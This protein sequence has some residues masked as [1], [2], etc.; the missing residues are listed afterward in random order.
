M[1][2]VG[3]FIDALIFAYL[4]AW[5]RIAEAEVSAVWQDRF[6]ICTWLKSG[7]V[8]LP[9]PQAIIDA[10]KNTG[11]E[12]KRLD[13]STVQPQ[14]GWASCGAGSSFGVIIQGDGELA[15]SAGWT[16]TKRYTRAMRATMAIRVVP[17]TSAPDAPVEVIERQINIKD[18]R[19]GKDW[20]D[21]GTGTLTAQDNN[22]DRYADLIDFGDT[23]G[24]VGTALD[25]ARQSIINARAQLA[26]TIASA[27]VKIAQERRGERLQTSTPIRPDLDIGQT[28]QIAHSKITRVG[29]V[30]TIH[31][32]IDIDAGSG[33]TTVEI[34]PY[35][36]PDQGTIPASAANYSQNQT[37]NI[38]PSAQP[39]QSMVDL[40]I[41]N[42][43]NR[44][45][46]MSNGSSTGHTVI[47]AVLT[48]KQPTPAE[49]VTTPQ[50]LPRTYRGGT[51]DMPLPE[52]DLWQGYMYNTPQTA[53]TTGT[54]QPRFYPTYQ[55]TGF[56]VRVPPIN[57]PD[58]AE[59]LD[60]G[61]TL[62]II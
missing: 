26:Y 43:I 38:N 45:Q 8:S 14:S 6:D 29:V 32:R 22:G 19:D 4:A 10:V 24:G 48:R 50:A 12:V 18:P 7:S 28:C 41:V 13:I 21:F 62:T 5:V 49:D 46:P 36:P 61:E 15:E 25:E 37:I 44:S 51:W 40:S 17:R 1:L 23:T 9:N 56:F 52:S 16:L 47:N 59:P 11:W 57:L 55:N 30:T 35:T 58:Q 31:H 27:A 39:G 54:Q 2:I 60:L 3:G 53:I 33:T 34:A 20:L 42:L